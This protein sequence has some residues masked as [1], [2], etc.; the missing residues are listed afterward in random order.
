MESRRGESEEE[1]KR[2]LKQNEIYRAWSSAA[3][4]PQSTAEAVM[5]QC[6]SKGGKTV[7]ALRPL[8]TFLHGSAGSCLGN[9]S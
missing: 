6:R 5:R 4:S 1:G 2:P 9:D 3:W 7:R 8:L